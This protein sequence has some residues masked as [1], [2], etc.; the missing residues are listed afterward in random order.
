MRPPGRSTRT[1]SANTRDFSGERL[2]KQ[3][4]RITSIEPSSTADTP[5]VP[6]TDH[7]SPPYAPPSSWIIAPLR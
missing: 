5:A 3:L 1:A 6:A 2:I 4:E 7:S